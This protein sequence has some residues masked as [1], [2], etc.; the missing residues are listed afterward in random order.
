MP[1]FLV[2]WQQ[3]LA[4][5]RGGRGWERGPGWVEYPTRDVS[6]R[7][8]NC[9]S[10]LQQKTRNGKHLARTKD[11]RQ[12]PRGLEEATS[13]AKE[14]K[15]S[16]REKKCN[17]STLFGSVVDNSYVVKRSRSMIGVWQDCMETERVGR[18][19]GDGGKETLP[20]AGSRC[21]Q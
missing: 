21:L 4:E 7:A 19:G 12:S 9:N 14:K 6:P 17:Q 5:G 20:W 18:W 13:N 10:V 2:M 15:G 8:R 16:S 11:N 1:V 3:Q